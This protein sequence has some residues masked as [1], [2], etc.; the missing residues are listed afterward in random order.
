MMLGIMSSFMKVWGI[1][2]LD[3]DKPASPKLWF[4]GIAS[5]SFHEQFS[6]ITS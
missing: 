1:S 6:Q 4:R 3:S 5:K 2:L